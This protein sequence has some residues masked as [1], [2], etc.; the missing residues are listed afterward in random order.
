MPRAM[1]SSAA[2]ARSS[3]RRAAWAPAFFA[4]LLLVLALTAQPA[5]AAGRGIS[6][7]APQLQRGGGGRALRQQQS[8]NQDPAQQIAAAVVPAATQAAVG[9]VNAVL[10]SDAQQQQGGTSGDI[11]T[12]HN[13]YRAVHHSPPLQWSSSLQSTAQAWANNLAAACQ[14]LEHSHT[15][16]VG[17]NLAAGYESWTAVAAAWYDEIHSYDYRSG[18]Y[19]SS[20]GHATQMLWA[21]SQQLGCATASS[22]QG[23]WQRTVYVCQYS[24][25]ARAGE[26]RGKLTSKQSKRVLPGYTKWFQ[27]SRWGWPAGN[28]M[29][30]FQQNVAAP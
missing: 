17:E 27:N 6:T 23:C 8:A 30:Q 25:P 12:L 18:S 24:P 16:G 7:A 26:M 21:T 15:Q 29:G 3:Q 28:V 20:T 2:A 5:C 11:L 1:A 22:A 10:S 19:S 9:T 4:A 13:Q 14:Q